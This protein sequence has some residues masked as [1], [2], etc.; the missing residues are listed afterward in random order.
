MVELRSARPADALALAEVQVAS[1]H[2]A[3]PGLIP[4]ARLAA[5]TVERRLV[6]WRRYLADQGPSTHT[7]LV[8]DQQRVVG[9]VTTGSSRDRSGAGE[10]WALYVDP[11]RWGHGAGSAL[12]ADALAT[13]ARRGFRQARLWVL[14]GNQ[15]AIGFYQGSGFALDG[16]R[17]VEDGLPQVRMT[18]AL[19]GG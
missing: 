5:Y 14:E 15:R 8:E 18:R 12:M 4:A 7:R 10:I 13:L 3:Y 19:T 11:E 16:V 1:W 6:A 2:A 9:F 17:M